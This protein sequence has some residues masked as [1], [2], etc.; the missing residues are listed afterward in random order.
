LKEER[1]LDAWKVALLH[2]EEVSSEVLPFEPHDV[3]VDAVALPEIV[4][5]FKR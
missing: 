1:T 2:D 3:R 5:R 4:V